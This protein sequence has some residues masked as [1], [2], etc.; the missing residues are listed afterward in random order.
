MFKFYCYVTVVKFNSDNAH[1]SELK[2]H[3]VLEDGSSKKGEMMTR[4][5]VVRLIKSGKK[6]KT[7]FL[8][9]DRKW[10]S[11]SELQITSIPME[12]LKTVKDAS[13]KD[14]LDNLPLIP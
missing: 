6:F 11:G 12:C 7:M 4:P 14:N 1:I 9:N 3:E 10:K 8:G 13:T 2:V 5:E